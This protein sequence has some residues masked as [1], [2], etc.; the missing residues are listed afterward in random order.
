MEYDVEIKP[1]KLIIGRALCENISKAAHM[2]GF[3]EDE[4]HVNEESG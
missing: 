3:N 1:I 2:I 4:E